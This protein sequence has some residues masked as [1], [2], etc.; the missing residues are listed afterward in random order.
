MFSIIFGHNVGLVGITYNYL[1]EVGVCGGKK[2]CLNIYSL[3]FRG[4]F[5]LCV[6]TVFSKLLN[7]GLN[8]LICKSFVCCVCACQS[9][10]LSDVIAALMRPNNA[11]VTLYASTTRAAVPIMSHSATI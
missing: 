3:V 2:Q 7:M 4:I 11:S 10:A 6:G 9:L 5:G 1:I 8:S